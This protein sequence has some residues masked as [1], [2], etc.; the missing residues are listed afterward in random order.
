MQS[1]D[2]ASHQM[3]AELESHVGRRYGVVH[4]WDEVNAP[5]IRQ[6]CEALGFELPSFTD[7]A[8]AARTVHG[9]IVAPASM[10]PVWLMPGLRN[11]RPPGSDLSNNREVM[12]VLERHGFVGILGTNCE[13][14]YER[15][16][17][18]G[19]KISCTYTTESISGEKQTRFG[20][21][22]FVTFLQEF[23]DA[24]SEVV[25]TMRLRVLRFRP[26]ERAAPALPASPPASASASPTTSPPQPT[27]S[28]DT[29]FFWEGLQRGELLIQRCVG[30]HELRHP[31]GPACMKCHCLEWDSVQSRGRGRL[32]SFVV[33]HKPQVASFGYPHPVGLV[34]LDEGVRL[35]APL[36]VA[37]PDAF[38]IGMRVQAVI[39]PVAGEY[40]LPRFEPAPGDPG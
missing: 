13:Q 27:L 20:A 33:M 39:E 23:R 34:E 26:H 38:E 10:L 3:L 24:Q 37:A 7:A 16:L 1:A 30:C 29:A 15:P 9:G 5:M 28:H 11:Q 21:G 40:R 6:W 36:S 2:A 18:P 22:F 4:A 14:E 31:P 12:D 17:R 19:E 32:V 8:A 35:V 25:G